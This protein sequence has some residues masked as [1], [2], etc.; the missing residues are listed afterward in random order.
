MLVT[1]AWEPISGGIQ[2]WGNER[3][4]R[5]ADPL[6]G[7]LCG[8]AASASALCVA[9]RALCRPLDRRRRI[10]FKDRRSQHADLVTNGGR[11]L[12]LERLGGDLH[13]RLELLH[14]LLDLAAAN[15]TQGTATL[16][17]GVGVGL[18]GDALE[19]I[20][21]VTDRLRDGGGGDAVIDIPLLLD[22][23]S[24]IRL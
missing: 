3:V 10:F 5:R 11:A 9:G 24:A 7:R 2:C 8:S 13:L 18:L 15:L 20:V 17:A 4:G 21:Q 14:Q 16:S 22:R 12:K 19:P 6:R 1:K 23:A